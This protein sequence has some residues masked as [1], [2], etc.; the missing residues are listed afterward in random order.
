MRS[1]SSKKIPPVSNTLQLLNLI[2][3]SPSFPSS[4]LTKC[5]LEAQLSIPTHPHPH[6]HALL[7]HYHCTH[8]LS[9]HLPMLPRVV[10]G[11]LQPAF[12]FIQLMVPLSRSSMCPVHDCL[13]LLQCTPLIWLSSLDTSRSGSSLF[14][15]FLLQQPSQTNLPCV[16]LSGS[17]L[18]GCGST[19]IPF[20]PVLLLPT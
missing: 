4:K 15:K 6:C 17:F 9:C 7:L 1:G 3:H 5:T 2:Y 20:N 10:S 13:R 12:I 16:D 18:T 14:C 8:P 19:N 11:C